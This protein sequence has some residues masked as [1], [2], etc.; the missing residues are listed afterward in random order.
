MAIVV[1][2]V[3]DRDLLAFM[4]AISV[5]DRATTAH[6]LA[7]MPELATARLLRGGTR[8]T[9]VDFFLS[10]IRMQLYAGDTALHVAAASYDTSL[11]RDL[12]GEGAD[13]RARNRRGAEPIHAAVIGGPGSSNWAPRKQAAMVKFLIEVGAPV[14]APAA[15]GV[16]P[17]LRAIRNRCSAAV[18]VLLDAGAD[19]RRTNDSGSSALDLARLTTGRSGSG[20]PEAKAEQAKIIEMLEAAKS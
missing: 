11:A 9:S 1:V 5:G 12:V 6:Q 4:R 2:V 16:T 19:P 14:E 7:T 13:V 20:T 8:T 18:R 10:E 15:G 3:D 17:L